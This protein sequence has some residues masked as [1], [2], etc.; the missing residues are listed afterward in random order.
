[1]PRIKTDHKK[2]TSTKSWPIRT[3]ESPNCKA[4]WLKPDQRVNSSN[5]KCKSQLKTSK[6]LTLI[7]RRWWTSKERNGLRP[8]QRREGLCKR[9]SAKSVHNC[10]LRLTTWSRRTSCW[11]T[12]TRRA[13]SGR[14]SWSRRST[15]CWIRST[16]AASSKSMWLTLDWATTISRML[17]KYLRNRFLPDSLHISCHFY[18]FIKYTS[19]SI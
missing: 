16:I 19:S 18:V 10:R 2:T 8:A 12:T 5:R 14:P 13:R 15:T 4:R 7:L 3:T 6:R 11:R 9:N 1:M 17:H